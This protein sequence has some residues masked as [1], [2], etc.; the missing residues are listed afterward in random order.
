MV[1]AVTAVPL[2]PVRTALRQPTAQLLK[3][4]VSYASV[5]AEKPV[6]TDNNDEL[7]SVWQTARNK[8]P[9]PAVKPAAKPA[10]SKRAAKRPAATSRN[11]DV[12]ERKLPIKAALRLA[13]VFVSRL[14][15][16]ESE[17]TIKRYLETT[18]KL[19]VKV[20]LCKLSETQSSFHVTSLCPNPSVFMDDDLWPVGVYRRWWRQHRS[21]S[22]DEET[23]VRTA[24][25]QHVAAPVDN[26]ISTVGSFHVKSS[27]F[28]PFFH[29]PPP[30][31]LKFGTLVELV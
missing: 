11:S 23:A 3:E 30:I 14:G 12:G 15:P 17:A 6:T 1:S 31:L 16:D 21:A 24:D 5:M 7:A 19:D 10:A 20:E 25:T 9:K 22:T 2:Q 13:N 28:L 27:D 29:G 26:D 8:R 4:G 18:L